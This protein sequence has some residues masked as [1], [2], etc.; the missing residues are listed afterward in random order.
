MLPPMHRAGRYTEKIIDIYTVIKIHK[1]LK[2]S[3]LYLFSVEDP[4]SIGF[5]VQDPD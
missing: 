1:L 4:H 3:S 5:E 2:V